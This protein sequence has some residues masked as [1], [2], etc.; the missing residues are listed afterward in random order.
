MFPAVHT[1]TG[2]D[3]PSKFG[4]ESAALKVNSCIY[5]KDFG[6]SGQSSHQNVVESAEK[7]LAQVLKK[8]TQCVIMDQ[9]R[10]YQYHHSKGFSL[11]QLPP[12]SHATNSHIMR[13]YHATYEIITI[14]SHTKVTLSPTRY[15]FQARDDLLMPDMAVR[16]ISEEYA[17][18]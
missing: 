5:L 17:L 4:T 16:H 9:L 1:I 11:E 15:G 8:G 10:N 18:Q 7:Y 3:Y 14:L 13:T 6:V 12:T 2:C